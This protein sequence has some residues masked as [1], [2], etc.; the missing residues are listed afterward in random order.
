MRGNLARKRLSR[1]PFSLIFLFLSFLL[2][3]IMTYLIR[4]ADFT[5]YFLLSDRLI[6]LPV[7][8]IFCFLLTDIKFK[9]LFFVA[10]SSKVRNY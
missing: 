10:N 9:V 6:I 5:S 7:D 1:Y 3:L 8:F 2:T 4:P